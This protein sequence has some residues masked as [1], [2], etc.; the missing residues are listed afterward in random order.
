MSASSSSLFIPS[1]RAS[2][3]DHSLGA[4]ISA[5]ELSAGQRLR[6]LIDTAP[7]SQRSTF[8]QELNDF[9][10]LFRRFIIG[11]K[12][13]LNWGDI[14]LP[15]SELVV[16]YSV[17]PEVE[18]PRALL[19]KLV[20][21]KL[22]GGLGTTM[23]CTGPKSAIEVRDELTFLD[24]VV[25]EIKELNTRYNVD[26]P[27]VL[28]NSFN[29]E[30]ATREIVARYP[31]EHI[32]ILSFNQSRHP[33]FYK[34]SFLPVAD[35]YDSPISCW[36]PPGHGDIYQSFVHSKLCRKLRKQGKEIIFISNIDNLGATVDF[37][38]LASLLKETEPPEFI[39]E[40][41]PKTRSD[42][43][44]GTLVTYNGVPRLLEL[45]QVPPE[46]L[47]EFK[48]VKKFKVFNTN[49]LWARLDAIER[50]VTEA[51][52]DAPDTLNTVDL[53]INHKKLDGKPV[54]QLETAAGSAIKCFKRAH[55]IEVPRSRFLPVKNTADLFILQ[56]NL[57][58]L[59]GARLRAN[60]N[61]PFDTLPVIKLDDKFS[62]VDDFLSR[63]PS[64]P[65]I[66]EL[67]HLTVSGDVFFGKGVV[68]R[69]TVIVVAPVGSRIDIPDGA[70]LE[71]KIIT[72]NLR[73][74]DH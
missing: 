27:L 65:D 69:G 17:L 62:Y 59:D 20:V 9:T 7:D 39:M 50:V 52:S 14:Q 70:I 13:K 33:R 72:G 31:Q 71:N 54:V 23:G 67:D 29:T 41:T 74:L 60:P 26:V 16:P 61:R 57:Y 11:Q 46:H 19:D 38:I 10:Y 24:L 35:R 18:D 21:L 47:N 2:F 66:L 8:I 73:I 34:D 4:D 45:A 68:L 64:I 44:G 25:T 12:E 49:N 55:G 58:K 53:I 63:F 40:L 6:S 28:M 30:K 3:G 36:Y 56:S 22:N 15:T 42:I 51:F 5:K 48:S 37:K 1:L 43:K 32:R